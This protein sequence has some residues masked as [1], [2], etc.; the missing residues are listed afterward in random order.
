MTAGVIMIVLVSVAVGAVV[1]SAVGFGLG[2]VA[3]PF[4]R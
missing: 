3:V 2:L 4:S 1:Q